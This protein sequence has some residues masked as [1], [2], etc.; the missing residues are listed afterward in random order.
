MKKTIVYFTC[1]F[2]LISCA[3]SNDTND[4]KGVA[5]KVIEEEVLIDTVS[6]Q[7]N[8]WYPG[9][10]QLKKEGSFDAN[11]LEHG[12]WVYYSEEGIELSMITY[13]HGLRQGFSIVRHENGY[14][15]GEYDQDEMVGLWTFYNEKGEKIDEKNYNLK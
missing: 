2:A 1:V 9:K 4:Y 5:E 3:E 7:Y 14:Y 12:K 15:R 10:K 11:Y 13:T 6:F 8:E